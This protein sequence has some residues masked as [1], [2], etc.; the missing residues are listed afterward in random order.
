MVPQR[1]PAVVCSSGETESGNDALR[2]RI[3][4]LT[5]REEI[6]VVPI[7]D[8]HVVSA[9]GGSTANRATW[10]FPRAPGGIASIGQV[11]QAQ[12]PPRR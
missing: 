6:E 12:W 7:R 11:D 3:H 9:H 2:R 4:E 10:A 8:R 1:V 5:P